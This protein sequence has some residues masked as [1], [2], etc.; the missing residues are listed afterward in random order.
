MQSL[1]AVTGRI[2]GLAAGCKQMATYLETV[3][4]GE[5]G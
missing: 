1:T 4:S 5:N 3:H 2:V